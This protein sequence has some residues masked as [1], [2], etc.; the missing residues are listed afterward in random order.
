MRSDHHWMTLHRVR[1]PEPVAALESSFARPDGP[2]CWRFCPGHNLGENKLPTWRS[3]T[4]CAFGIYEDRAAAQMVFDA[5]DNHFPA[6]AETVESWHA[7]AVPIQHR[8]DVNW[9]GQVQSDCAV[10]PADEDF[11]GILAVMTSASFND[12]TNPGE[13]P[14]ISRF[15]V[16]VSEAI[17]FLGQQPGNLRRAV[18]NGGFDG[19]EGFTLTLW[20]SDETMLKAAYHSG[21]HRMLMDESRDGSTFDRSSF[22]RLRIVDSR[23][24]W[25][26]DPLELAA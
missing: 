20:E 16:K 5:P 14:R 22:T 15:A 2:E 13:L 12:P 24:S 26:G 25:S 3:D 6:L 10:R 1:F 4:W 23:G 7:L 21:H 8:G 18:F 17:E 11:P 9:R 19:L